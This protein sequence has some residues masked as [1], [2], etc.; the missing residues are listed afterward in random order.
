MLSEAAADIRRADELAADRRRRLQARRASIERLDGWLQE[1]E[2][3]LEHDRHTVPEALVGEIGDFVG[4]IDPKL[5]NSLMR[6]ADREAA[7][8]LDV[9][10][11]AQEVVL[12]RAIAAS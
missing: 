4:Q 7:A 6:N 9:L 2:A 11:D 10:F 12:P 8:V 3:M 5:R 1:V